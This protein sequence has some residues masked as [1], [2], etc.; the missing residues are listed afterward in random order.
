[1]TPSLP[2][3]W[4]TTPPGARNLP[5]AGTIGSPSAVMNRPGPWGPDRQ[6]LVGSAASVYGD[7]ENRPAPTA[8]EI[9]SGRAVVT[10]GAAASC[11]RGKCQSIS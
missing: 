8:A 5:S 10:G 6:S 1:M 4:P 2:R 9:R 3:A 11:S 7:A